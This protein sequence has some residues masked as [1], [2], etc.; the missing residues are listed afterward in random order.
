MN[1]HL[2]AAGDPLETKWRNACWRDA[3]TMCTFH[4]IGGDRSGVRDCL[5]RN[6][7]RI[8]KPCRAVIEDA[9]AKG[10]H[11]ARSRDEPVAST[12]DPAHD[13]SSR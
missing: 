1:L 2:A 6:I 12:A 4:A 9:N 5:V 13:P 8:S 3:F 10:I 11:D 7:D